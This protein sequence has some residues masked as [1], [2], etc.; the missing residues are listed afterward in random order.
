MLSIKSGKI[1]GEL[2]DIYLDNA[3]STKVK[4][5]VL[6]KFNEV[7]E[8]L[9]GNP[10]SEHTEGYLADNCIEMV[11]GNI[12]A[13]LHCDNDDVFFTTGATM[14]NQLLIQGFIAKHPNAMI[15]TTNVEHNDIMILINNVIV[16]RHIL[17][18]GKDGLVNLDELT[19]VLRYSSEEMTVPTLV[20]IQMANSETGIIQPIQKISNICKKYDNVFLHMDATQYIPYYPINM[21]CWGI[22]AISMSGQKIGGIK[23]S[24]LLV[25]R[26]A[27]RENIKP[28]IY[29][30]QGLIGGTP[31]TPLIASLGEAFNE[32]DYDTSSLK[33]KR[34]TLWS[35]LKDIGA[36]MVGGLDNRLP[37]NIYCRFPGINGLS[38]LHLLDEYDIYIGTGSACSTD[39]DKPSHVA[40]AYGLT[41]NEALECVRFTLSDETNY[42]DIE[43]V[44]RVLKSILPL[45]R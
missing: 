16:Y 15:I 19:E 14:S 3:A 44:V 4:P 34:N 45:I 20:T 35:F 11:K 27:L 30:E 42:E 43:Y 18:V 40:K 36:I 37:N 17:R 39:S 32:I 9:Y 13:K 29:G 2:M 25:V 33:D 31:S 8:T 38:L 12:S 24:G 28:I 7:A 6:I 26:Q 41:D 1:G 21:K 23:G 22:D 5:S 10:S